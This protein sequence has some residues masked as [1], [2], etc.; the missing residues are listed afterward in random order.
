MNMAM[1]TFSVFLFHPQSS[2][3][4]AQCVITSHNLEGM[5]RRAGGTGEE[6]LVTIFSLSVFASFRSV[7]IWSIICPMNALNT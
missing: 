4:H 7:D 3:A 2:P 1:A 5:T 6:E